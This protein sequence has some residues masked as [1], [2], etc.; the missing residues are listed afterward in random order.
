MVEQKGLLISYVEM[1]NPFR[2]SIGVVT[3]VEG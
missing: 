2:W 1:V 3:R